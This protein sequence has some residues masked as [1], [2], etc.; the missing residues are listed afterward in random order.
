M[1]QHVG[2][3]SSHAVSRGCRG[4]RD[5]V[6]IVVAAGFFVFFFEHTHPAGSTRPPCLIHLSTSRVV[7][8]FTRFQWWRRN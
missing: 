6:V 4:C 3:V 1:V 7:I 8:E 5:A 2:D